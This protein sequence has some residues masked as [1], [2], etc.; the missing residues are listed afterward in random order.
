M[1]VICLSFVVEVI[2]RLITPKKYIKVN[3]STNLSSRCK[4]NLYDHSLVFKKCRNPQKLSVL[5]RIHGGVTQIMSFE[6]E[7]RAE[8]C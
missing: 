5:D 8:S 4:Y 7:T 1:M 3:L 2:Y 6:V